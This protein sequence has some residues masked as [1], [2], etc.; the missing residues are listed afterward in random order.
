MRQS[1]RAPPA[2]RH[3][4]CIS[5][6]GA[7]PHHYAAYGLHVRSPFV[8]PFTRC[9]GPPAGAPDVTV[10]LGT[11]PATLPAPV[12]ACARWEAAP[13][14][15]LLTVDGVARYLATD[16]RDV[17]VE[18]RG[19]GDPDVGV[20]LAG[21]VFGALLQQ[22]GVVTLHASAVATEAGAVL[23]VGGSGCGKSSLAAAL[24]ARGYAL[25]ADNVTGVVLEEDGHVVALP[26]FPGV[27]LWADALDSLGWQA[28]DRVRPSLEKYL[29]PVERFR[30]VPSAVCAVTLL[31]TSGRPAGT[32]EPASRAAAFKW[33]TQHTYHGMFLRGL[34]RKQAHFRTATALAASVPATRVTHGYPFCPGALAD[35]VVETLPAC[36]GRC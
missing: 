21:P 31:T 26:A 24:V 25:M 28:R 27:C 19:G 20:F 22:R 16:G 32:I 15:F 18:P 10:H 5:T 2:E 7:S 36:D 29:V 3:S 17:L 11:T 4:R 30:S 33:L 34:G 9:P 12:E 1:G 35:R 13:G 8:L 14:A 23:F 6:S